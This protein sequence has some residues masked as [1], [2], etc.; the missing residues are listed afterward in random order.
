MEGSIGSKIPYLDLIVV[1]TG[2]HGVSGEIDGE[3]C[4]RC[5]A[6]TEHLGEIGPLGGGPQRDGSV[7]VS[8]MDDGIGRIVS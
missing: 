1:A 2:D 7:A 6:M 8:V 4:D 5:A 3:G